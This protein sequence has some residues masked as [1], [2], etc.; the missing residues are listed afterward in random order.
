MGGGKKMANQ[1]KGKKNC[2]RKRKSRGKK[3]KPVRRQKG[4]KNTKKGKGWKKSKK[5]KARNRQKGQ[6]DKTI[7]KPP[8]AETPNNPTTDAPTTDN[9]TTDNPTTDTDQCFA[10]MDEVRKMATKGTN[11]RKQYERMM[12][13][14]DIGNTK[15]GMAADFSITGVHLMD[16]GGGNPDAPACSGDTSG[17]GADKLKAS[18]AVLNGCESSISTACDT[19]TYPFPADMDVVMTCS[20]DFEVL[21]TA[22]REC[23]NLATVAEKCECYSNIDTTKAKECEVISTEMRSVKGSH[24]ACTNAFKACAKEKKGASSLL[25]A[26]SQTVAAL[27]NKGAQAATNSKALDDAKS[28]IEGKISRAKNANIKRRTRSLPTTCA[29]L[30]TASE[31][32]IELAKTNPT[33]AEVET[34]ANNIVSAAGGITCTEAA[35]RSSLTIIIIGFTEAKAVVDIVVKAIFAAIGESTGTTPTE[36]SIGALTEA[37]VVTPAAAVRRNRLVRDILAGL[38]NN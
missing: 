19:S 35:P 36:E 32:L 14:K 3:R 7:I 31:E 2:G 1:G 29:E 13:F 38:N 4:R 28:A 33:S 24:K 26:C 6:K 27:A 23:D 15:A 9:P 37:P 25:Y 11:Y 10:D 30:I 22:Q 12:K 18:I 21:I 8:A 5:E 17:S 16:I 20:E 34:K